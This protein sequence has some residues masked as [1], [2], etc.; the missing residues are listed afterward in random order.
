MHQENEKAE[1]TVDKWTRDV[2][3]LPKFLE[4]VY[5]YVEGDK[6]L[7][8]EEVNCKVLAMLNKKGLQA[9]CS[10]DLQTDAAAGEDLRGGQQDDCKNSTNDSLAAIMALIRSALDASLSKGTKQ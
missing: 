10:D 4:N 8:V 9:P 2:I 7:H 1:G 3:C 6:P 5:E